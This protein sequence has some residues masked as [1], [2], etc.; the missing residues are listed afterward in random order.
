MTNHA[1][2]LHTH[3]N[4]E[5]MK[6]HGTQLL[7]D[8]GIYEAAIE[9]GWHYCPM[10]SQAG[11][12]PGWGYTVPDSKT[13]LPYIAPTTNKPIKRWKN[14][15]SNPDIGN[16]NGWIPNKKGSSPFYYASDIRE[17]ITASQGLVYIAAGETDLLS[18]QS[19]GIRNVF[20][21][22]DGEGSVPDDLLKT[23]T[24]LEVKKVIYIT[25]NDP[26]GKRSALRT[27]EKLHGGAIELNAY[28]PLNLPEK[29]DINDLWVQSGFDRS[30]FQQSLIDIQNNPANRIQTK[31]VPIKQQ[32]PRVTATRNQTSIDWDRERAEWV[33]LEV[34]PKLDQRSPIVEGKDRRNCPSPTHPDA[35]PSFRISY[36]KDSDAGIPQCS[37]DIQHEKQPWDK[38]GEWVG[39]QPFMDWWNEERKPLFTP[40]KPEKRKA[41]MA[42][43]NAS[44]QHQTDGNGQEK[45]ISTDDEIGDQIIMG[46]GGLICH[47]NNCWYRYLDGVWKAH[48]NIP[49]PIWKAMQA[50]KEFEVRPSSNRVK[51]IEHYLKSMLYIDPDL[52]ERGDE[53]LNLKN[54]LFNLQ[55]KQLESHRPDLYHTTQLDFGYDPDAKAPQ[56]EQFLGNALVDRSG[57]T[58]QGLIAAIQEAMGYSLTTDTNFEKGFWLFGEP[59]SGKSTILNVLKALL[60]NAFAH[61]DFNQLRNN[62]YQLA[63]IPGKRVLACAEAKTNSTLADNFVKTIISGEVMTIREIFQQSFTH[64]PYAKLW[65]AMN[66]LP[67]NDDRSGAIQRRLIIIPF[68]RS[69]PPDQLDNHL[70]DKLITE[71]PGI[72]NWALL[73]LKRLQKQGEFTQT[74]EMKQLVENYQQENDIEKA[75]LDSIEWCV[76]DEN[77]KTQSTDLYFAYKAWCEQ[78]GHVFKSS[79]RIAREWDRLKLLKSK[80]GVVYYTGVSLTGYAQAVVLSIKQNAGSKGRSR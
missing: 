32:T 39:A 55:T 25:D 4:D 28:C 20:C 31:R 11:S 72:F 8:R 67:G 80:S 62:A 68:F 74:D 10:Q 15:N 52:I 37:C 77:A 16:K 42:Q 23:L 78:F 56:W 64:K 51:S 41:K 27:A 69:V 21:W 48:R 33:K 70:I 58:D 53:Y 26:T 18:Y 61:L 45:I 38:V 75:F 71:L 63:Q 5:A 19:A 59:S 49:R 24:D 47:M 76:R 44:I 50:A 2:N 65:W 34:M 79:T 17:S 43:T 66:E 13:G 29:G 3:A 73:G 1:V 36:D 7:K 60:G 14:Y 12:I 6:A 22:L 35:D 9:M 54:G 30:Q 57:A 46:W 40:P